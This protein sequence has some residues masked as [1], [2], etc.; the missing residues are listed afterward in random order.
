MNG[1]INVYKEAGFTSFDVVAK[2]RGVLKQKKIGHT[3]TLDPDATGVLPICLGTATKVCDLLTDR[4][5]EYI[6]TMLLGVETDTYDCSGTVVNK[7]PVEVNEERISE[8]LHGFVGESMQIPPMYSALKVNGKKLYEYAR[9]GIKIE[10]KPRKIQIYDLEILHI[11]LP[12]VEFRVHCSKGTYIRSICYDA[13][14]IAQC[15]ACMK[16]LIRT[17]VDNFML[18]DAY[19]LNEIEELVKS[20]DVNT[21]VKPV[22]SVFSQYPKAV[23]MDE[24]SKV[25]YNGNRLKKQW[26]CQEMT[27]PQKVRIYDESGAFIGI[28]RYEESRKEFKPEKIFWR[29]E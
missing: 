3:G 20:G 6:A 21:I 29:K 15:G 12:E 28:Y 23:V 17:R 8:I 7:K 11:H 5:K 10:R 16:K 1:I 18:E 25:L 4:S 9:E 24:Y 13:G 22:D 2:L 26:V 27:P 19:T 14:R